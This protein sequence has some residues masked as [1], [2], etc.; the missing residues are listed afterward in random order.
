MA[1]LHQDIRPRQR[2][3]VQCRGP[4]PGSPD[5]GAR[6]GPGAAATMAA[7]AAVSSASMRPPNRRAPPRPPASPCPSAPDAPPR[8]SVRARPRS[9]TQGAVSPRTGRRFV[10]GQTSAARISRCWNGQSSRRVIKG[11]PFP[12]CPLGRG[13]GAAVVVNSAPKPRWPTT[14]RLRD[15]TALVTRPAP[16]SLPG[17]RVEGRRRRF[18]HLAQA[19]KRRHLAS[20][21]A[22][23]TDRLASRGAARG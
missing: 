18:C 8:Q 11:R 3:L 4:T 12:A 9:V 13:Q 15:R 22:G 7:S 10:S 17:R 20:V 5:C 2:R 23:W 1:A 16:R 6:A 21:C 19:V 14:S